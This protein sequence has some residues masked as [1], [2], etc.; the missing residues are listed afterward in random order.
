LSFVN[1]CREKENDS[2]SCTASF[3]SLPTSSQCD[4]DDDDD[5]EPIPKDESTVKRRQ[6]VETSKSNRDSAVY[7]IG[8]DVDA[9]WTEEAV[10]PRI[11][12]H[13]FAESKWQAPTPRACAIKQVLKIVISNQINHQVPSVG[14]GLHSV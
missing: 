6:W 1:V 7:D 10:G 13:S 3:Y 12:L 11:E 8:V 9:S 4:E 2:M 14:L 5:L